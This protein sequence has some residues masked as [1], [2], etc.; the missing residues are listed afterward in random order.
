MTLLAIPQIILNSIGGVT[1]C[2]SVSL[3]LELEKRVPSPSTTLY[4]LITLDSY[5]KWRSSFIAGFM[6]TSAL[7][8]FLFGSQEIF[9]TGTRLFESPEE[10]LSGVSTIGFM[11]CG[12]LVGVGS[13]LADGGLTKFGFYG[14]PRLSKR[15]LIALN[16]IIGV[17]GIV[18]NLRAHHSIF[19]ENDLRE[20]AKSFDS[21]LAILV[22]LGLLIVS[23][24]KTEARRQALLSFSIGCLLSIGVMFSGLA[25]RHKMINFLTFSSSWDPFLLIVFASA[26]I[27]N[28]LLFRILLRH[29]DTLEEKIKSRSLDPKFILGCCFLGAGLGISG[30]TPGSALLVTPI[31]LPQLA[32]FFLPFVAMGQFCADGLGIFVLDELHV[33]NAN[34]QQTHPKTE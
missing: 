4:N 7:A 9:G 33:R 10:F 6:F 18:A 22:P 29:N 30:L 25:Q 15:A 31:Y 12:F 19:V 1:I 28:L 5:T 17:G 26:I 13:K 3:D 8:Y 16:I 27:A 21:R 20:F 34:V 24:Y 14:L 11:I 32:L 2:G 23:L